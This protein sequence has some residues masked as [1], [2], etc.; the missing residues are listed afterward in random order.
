MEK[1]LPKIHSIVV[2]SNVLIALQRRDDTL[3][4]R[5]KK[6]AKDLEKTKAVFV[7]NNYLIAEVLTVLFLKTKNLK[8]PLSFGGM[9]YEKKNPWFKIYEIGPASQKKAWRIFKSQ[10]P[11]DR[12]SF[13]DCTLPVLAGEL[14]IKTIFSFD[15]KFKVFKK[16]GF[17]ILG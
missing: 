7:V 1:N 17:E 3:Y 10:K 6:I 4:S 11:S 8:A 12:L 15:K 13:V 2:D 16:L 5:A 14:D 9:V